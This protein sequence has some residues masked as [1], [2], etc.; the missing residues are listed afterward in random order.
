MFYVGTVSLTY[1]LIVM[2]VTGQVQPMR[3][4]FLQHPE[5]IVDVL[6]LSVLS[7]VGQIFIYHTVKHHGP[8]TLTLIMTTRQVASIVL[9]CALFH[10]GIPQV[11]A[12]AAGLVFLVIVF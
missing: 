11:A 12:L 10:H 9:S 8:V 3:D 5:S 1:S 7:T 4:F 6:G 2:S